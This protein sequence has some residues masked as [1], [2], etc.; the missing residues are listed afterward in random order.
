MKRYLNLIGLMMLLVSPA[1]FAQDG[2]DIAGDPQVTITQN[3]NETIE[4]YRVNGEL[5]QIK[6]TP[7]KGIPYYLVDTDGD[8]R[9]DQRTN[10][11][12]ED[13][14]IPQWMLFRWN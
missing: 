14:L 11:L 10:D 6:I 7:N 1:L 9:L 5:F 4:E 13:I 3:E 8:G 2:P 12:S